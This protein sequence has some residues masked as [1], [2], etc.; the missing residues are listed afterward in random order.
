MERFFMIMQ[1]YFASDFGGEKSQPEFLGERLLWYR[2]T[3]QR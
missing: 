2:Q 1:K 3:A